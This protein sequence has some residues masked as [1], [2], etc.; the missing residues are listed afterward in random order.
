MQSHVR[1]A[2]SA[3]PRGSRGNSLKN[4]NTAHS[5]R[6]DVL[7]ASFTDKFSEKLGRTP[8]SLTKGDKATKRKFEGSLPLTGTYHGIEPSSK[9]KKGANDRVIGSLGEPKVSNVVPPSLE[10]NRN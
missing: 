4:D 6:K 1:A 7:A 8:I 2:L 5:P 9:R 10:D 3:A